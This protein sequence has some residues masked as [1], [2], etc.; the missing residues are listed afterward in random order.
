MS[1][2]GIDFLANWVKKNVTATD[3]RGSAT[4][5]KSSIALT[6]RCTQRKQQAETPWCDTSY[7]TN[8][9]QWRKQRL[10]PYWLLL[11][12]RLLNLKEEQPF[13]ERLPRVSGVLR[14]YVKRTKIRNPQNAMALGAVGTATLGP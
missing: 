5:R 12:H 3:R 10:T 8:L 1:G 14:P 7:P 9:S 4:W 13:G 11:A 2:R 6:S